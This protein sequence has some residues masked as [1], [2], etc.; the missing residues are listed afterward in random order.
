M[1]EGK[2]VK[3][4]KTAPWKH[5]LVYGKTGFRR[6]D[7]VRGASRCIGGV[8]EPGS[9]GV[10]ESGSREASGRLDCVATKRGGSR[11]FE[12]ELILFSFHAG[13]HNPGMPF[14]DETHSTP[15]H[16]ARSPREPD[17]DFHNH[18][19]SDDDA[20]NPFALVMQSHEPSARFRFLRAAKTL[21]ATLV[22]TGVLLGGV[23]FGKQF[24]L[25]RLVAGFDDLDSKTQQSRLIQIASFGPDAVE[26]LVSK[27][28]VPED[29]VSES[30][31]TLLQQMQ[32]DWVTLPPE[33]AGVMHSRL[34]I[35]IEATYR[36]SLPSDET[37]SSTQTG[38]NPRQISR[39][40]E[41]V[42][43][44]ILEFSSSDP[45]ERASEQVQQ[46]LAGANRLLADL[47]LRPATTATL[48]VSGSRLD[49][50]S[51]DDRSRSGG[52]S[53]TRDQPLGGERSGWTDWP[54]PARSG[55]AQIVVSGP[56]TGSADG[57]DAA[58]LPNLK[59]VPEGG[60]IA[61]TRVNQPT[62]T[63]PPVL[64]ARRPIGKVIQMTTHLADSPL[65][66]LDDETVI[67]HLANPDALLAGQA[68]AELIERGFSDRQ[69]E[70]AT[71]LAVAGPDDRMRLIDSLVQSSGFHSGPWL[72]MLLDDPDRRVRLHVA[73][74]FAMTEDPAVLARLRQRL[75]REQDNH[76]AIRLRRILDLD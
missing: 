17:P 5:C 49:L 63:P 9:R 15:D 28:I 20:P 41:L 48:V 7:I 35:A 69:L 68:K 3:L 14:R 10:G 76:V 33:T 18:D 65:A 40:R 36:G 31:F 43:Q 23:F 58:D 47:N 51:P 70:T 53:P 55:T 39:T 2:A 12:R 60:I 29:A 75:F 37:A 56:K 26:P 42:R 11:E 6:K 72:S 52:P 30:A 44:T 24:L 22:L 73:A 74:K 67:R 62:P 1:E 64:A 13:R 4:M 21:L 34:I 57:R 66:A 27:L 8:G 46:T 45:T 19:F 59:A 54:P 50:A 61:L 38:L 25:Y 71:A 32:N 16:A